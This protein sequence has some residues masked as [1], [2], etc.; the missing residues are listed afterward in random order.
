[1]KD[2]LLKRLELLVGSSVIGLGLLLLSIF[3]SGLDT[4]CRR[5]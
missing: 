3:I 4:N 2:H 1:M 5:H